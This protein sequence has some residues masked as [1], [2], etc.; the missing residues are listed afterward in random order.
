MWHGET[1][2]FENFYSKK[3]GQMQG[4]GGTI[5]EYTNSIDMIILIIYAGDMA[6][7]TNIV[8]YINV[9]CIINPIKLNAN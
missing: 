9:L 3:Q 7:T 8:N 6:Y 2:Y 1:S 4:C 5:R